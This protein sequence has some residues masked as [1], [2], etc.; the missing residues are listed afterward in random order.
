MTIAAT[1]L[2]G[3]TARP[4]QVTFASQDSCC[5]FGPILHLINQRLQQMD[6]G[7]ETL[8]ESIG[9]QPPH[10]MRDSP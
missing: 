4:L 5:L 2:L 6:L 10:K 1:P 7:F 9:R 8:A 3:D